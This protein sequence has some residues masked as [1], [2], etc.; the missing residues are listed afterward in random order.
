[1]PVVRAEAEV[2]LQ[3]RLFEQIED[4]G[5]VAGVGGLPDQF[6]VRARALTARRPE[7]PLVSLDESG[8]LL[9]SRRLGRRRRRVPLLGL[10]QDLLD[11]RGDLQAVGA[12]FDEPPR[13][14]ASFR[15]ACRI[16]IS[17][18]SPEVCT[19]AGS[20]ALTRSTTLPASWSR[21]SKVAMFRSLL[22]KPR[23]H[24]R[25]GRWPCPGG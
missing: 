12:E 17:R 13:R 20:L 5:D 16:A 23:V 15:R 9:Q 10:P 7:E 3:R 22:L 21:S 24:Q 6:G 19:P 2:G 1:V 25:P 11:P 14:S 8:D 18:G 4:G